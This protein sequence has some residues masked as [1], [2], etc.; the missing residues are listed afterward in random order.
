MNEKKTITYT[1]SPYTEKVAQLLDIENKTLPEILTA[2]R[3]I[4]DQICEELQAA[5][6]TASP[7]VRYTWPKGIKQPARGLTREAI[8]RYFGTDQEVLF[9]YIPTSQEV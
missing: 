2:L 4:N 8:A 9:N 6:C 7:S 5:T 1:P 3:G